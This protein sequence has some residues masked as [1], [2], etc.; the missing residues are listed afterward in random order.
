MTLLKKRKLNDITEN[1]QKSKYFENKE[2]VECWFNKFTTSVN[3]I[4]FE[5]DSTFK[6][7]KTEK[8]T[9]LDIAKYI[10]YFNFTKDYIL[11]FHTAFWIYE[12]LVLDSTYIDFL[13]MYKHWKELDL[14]KNIKPF[15]MNII[16]SDEIYC[17]NI[18]KKCLFN[19]EFDI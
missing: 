2:I 4:N 19:K 3:H 5:Y 17:K 12:T 14:F 9:I 16:C 13:E 7:T 8:E 11:V 15:F 18:R 6:F 1:F 10:E